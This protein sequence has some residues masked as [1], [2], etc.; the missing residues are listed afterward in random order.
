MNAEAQ[1]RQAIM[2]NP[3]QAER[4]KP[5]GLDMR[6]LLTTEAT[7]GVISVIMAWHILGEGP[8]IMSISARKKCFSSYRVPMS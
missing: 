1:S 7:D 6:V 3:E 8:L 2:V 4:I 5:F